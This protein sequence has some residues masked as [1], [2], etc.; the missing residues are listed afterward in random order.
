[1]P[2]ALA[3]TKVH[4]LT[5]HHNSSD[6]MFSQASAAL[7][8]QMAAD[9]ELR[10]KKEKARE[11]RNATRTQ[12]WAETRG[13]MSRCHHPRSQPHF[14]LCSHAHTTL[15]SSQTRSHPLFFAER[16]TTITEVFSD[17]YKQQAILPADEWDTFQATLTKPLPTTFR[18]SAISGV[19]E[20]LREQMRSNDFSAHDEGTTAKTME[21]E[22]KKRLKA[23]S[24]G[25][26]A[27]PA[28]AAAATG[29][30][31]AATATP[32]VADAAAAAA[33]AAAAGAIVVGK[34]EERGGDGLTNSERAAAAAAAAAKPFE[35]VVPLA[36]YPVGMGW[37]W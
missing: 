18:L 28:A 35:G 2:S 6:S 23:A 17:Y 3:L 30:G 19:H 31:D 1:V 34:D 14:G 10:A 11:E 29:D 27:T 25:A 20:R 7:R 5:I 8:H 36:W 32:A 4:E 9:P 26:A 21:P 15:H 37:Q 12:E 13:G 33:A 24:S 22:E 16:Q